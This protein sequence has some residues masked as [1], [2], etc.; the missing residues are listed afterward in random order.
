MLNGLLV[1]PVFLVTGTGNLDNT[2]TEILTASPM[3][4]F[5]F[6]WPALC[7]N[8]FL[9]SVELAEAFLYKKGLLNHTLLLSHAFFRLINFLFLSLFGFV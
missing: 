3:F 2:G 5:S 9:Q 6:L 4:S 8:A 1:F 7:W